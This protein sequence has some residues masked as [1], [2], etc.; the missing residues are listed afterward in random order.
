MLSWEAQQLQSELARRERRVAAQPER[1]LQLNL[2]LVPHRLTFERA[3]GTLDSR[4]RV[5]TGDLEESLRLLID[6]SAEPQPLCLETLLEL[7]RRLH[8]A[9]PVSNL[10][11]GAVVPLFS[12]HQPIPPASIPK[13]L[14]RLFEWLSSPAFA[15]IHPSGQM[16]LLQARLLE[17]HPF[18][19]QPQILAS[20]ASAVLP[21]AT[22]LL[23]PVPVSNPQSCLRYLEEAARFSTEPLSIWNL[24]ACLRAFQLV[25]SITC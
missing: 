1:R 13:A 5:D 6:A 17:I 12:G 19:N 15:E 8:P 3:W 14:E 25:D 4:E 7:R 10:R 16:A 23:L 20:V 22:G 21:M 24:R 2:A 9:D 11:D 18:E